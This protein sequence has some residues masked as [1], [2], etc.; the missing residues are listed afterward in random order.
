MLSSAAVPAD[1]T[2]PRRAMKLFPN[3]HVVGVGAVWFPWPIRCACIQVWTA[4]PVKRMEMEGVYC[5]RGY[6]YL[7]SR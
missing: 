5:A 2:Q 4:V 3:A 7:G 6:G 1:T